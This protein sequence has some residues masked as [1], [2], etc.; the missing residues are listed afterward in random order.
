MKSTAKTKIVQPIM[1]A[2]CPFRK[3]SP[4][5]WLR[6][7]VADSAL[8]DGN[9]ICHSTGRNN[10]FHRETGKPERLCRGARDLQLQLFTALGFLEEPTD[11]E[12][13]RR[14]EELGC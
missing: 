13:D 8:N 10:L 2:T 5:A 6:E 1:C 12:W 11:E 3:G 4:T 9:R 14:C 7:I